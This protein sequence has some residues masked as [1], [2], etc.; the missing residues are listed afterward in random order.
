MTD[1]I[2]PQPG[3][4]AKPFIG[5]S[6]ATGIMQVQSFAELTQPIALQIAEIPIISPRWQ[7]RKVHFHSEVKRAILRQVFEQIGD[8]QIALDD[9]SIVIALVIET[10]WPQAFPSRRICN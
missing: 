2:D 4:N 5:Q 6:N 10:G 7:P 1:A 3:L 9:D 8:R